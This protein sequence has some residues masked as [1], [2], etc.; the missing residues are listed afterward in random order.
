MLIVD[1]NALQTVDLLD[2][3]DQVVLHIAQ[4]LDRQDILGIEHTLT[5]DDVAL[6]HTVTRHDACMLG[7][8]D[9]VA[10]DHLCTGLSSL[11]VTLM[12]TFFLVSLRETTPEISLMMAMSW[13]GGS[14][15]A[16][17]HEADPG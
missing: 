3:A 2:L 12:T 17:Q 5:G 9:G 15:T 1:L 16:P 7:K 14:R 11:P 4:A 10:L 6:L 13:D 8:G